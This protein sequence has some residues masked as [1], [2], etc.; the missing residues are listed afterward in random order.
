MRYENIKSGILTI[1]VLVSILLTWSLWTYQPKFDMLEENSNYVAGVTVSEKQE[2]QKIVKPDQVLFHI[3]GQHYGT[4]SSAELEKLMKD[5]GRWSIFDVRNYSDKVENIEELIHSSGNAEIIFP[6]EVPIELYR[7]VLT[8]EGKRVPSFNFN[9]IIINVD[10][11]E[12]EN[13]ILYFVSSE[14]QQVYIGHISSANVNEFNREFYKNANR[15]P[16]Y[17]AYKATDKHTLFLPEAET[18]M[19]AYKYLPVT[20]NSDE[21]KGALFNDPRFVQ[22]S[23]VLPQS[24]EYTNDSSKLIINNDT[25][26][27]SYVN[28]TAADNYLDSSYGLVK[29][30]IDFVNEHGGWTDAFRY[31][32]K[33]EYKQSVTF[34]LYSMEG[35]PVFNDRGLSEINEVWG[36]DEINRYVRPNISL[37]LVTETKKATLPSGHAVVEYLQKKKNFKP[38]LLDKLILGYRMDRDSEEKKLILLEPAWFYLYDGNWEQITMENQGGLKYGLE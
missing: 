32:S 7:S 8:I 29:R 27:L 34:R 31:V 37:D 3:K 17:F 11:A 14:N 4:N 19:T 38:E 9:R 5:M 1:L 25:N 22:K 20:L 28:P 10:N 26:I 33:S 6:G 23:F 35:Y 15:Y 16:Q 2:V 13:G 24:E 21:F 18:E 36:K 30:S 12:K